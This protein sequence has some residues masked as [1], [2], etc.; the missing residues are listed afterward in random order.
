LVSLIGASCRSIYGPFDPFL[1]SS[2]AQVQQA[3]AAASQHQISGVTDP[4]IQVF[5][6]LYLESVE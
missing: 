5:E 3:I 6:R 1:A 4:R 2:L